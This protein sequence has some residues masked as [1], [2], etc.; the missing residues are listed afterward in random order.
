MVKKRVLDI[1]VLTAARQRVKRVFALKRKIILSFSGG[2]DS[3]VLAHIVLSMIQQGE[4]DKSLLT[5]IFIDEEAMYE[6]V[7]ETVK[8][9]RMMFMQEGV[10]FLWY[11]LPVKHYNCLNT[12][13]D[14]ET[15]ICWDPRKRDVWVRDMPKFAIK[16]DDFLI[17]YKDN[18]QSWQDRYNKAHK[19]IVMMGVRVS[20]SVQ[21]M[22]NFANRKSEAATGKSYPIYDMTDKDIWLYIM[23]YNINIPEVYENLY[24]V[25]TPTN[26]LRVSQFFSIDTAKA[27]VSL[28]EL[29]PDLMERVTRREPNAYLCAMYWDTE[30]FGRTTRK[31]KELENDD[32]KKDYR[33]LA[34]QEIRKEN[35]KHPD[36]IKSV[37]PLIVKASHLMDEKDWKDI[38]QILQTGDPKKR[39]FRAISMHVYGKEKTR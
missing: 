39:T 21:R 10:K 31:R 2:K 19:Y 35:P 25:G 29:Y 6:D 8:E 37:K 33:S 5:V 18:Y 32:E 1:D 13:S 30:M 17:P 23:R 11:C 22:K 9:W 12:M 4:I 3:I 16:D 36:V 14:E 7:I 20:E 24:R 34:M 15:F 28:G 38:Y 26:R 27:L